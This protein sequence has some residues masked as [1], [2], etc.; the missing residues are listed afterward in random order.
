MK[1]EQSIKE[2]LK[3]YELRE[4]NLK[5]IIENTNEELKANS[6]KIWTLRDV[7]YNGDW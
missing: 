5:K 4:L 6:H 2:R 3:L 1:T 7:L